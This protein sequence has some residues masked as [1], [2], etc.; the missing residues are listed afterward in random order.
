VT[1]THLLDAV[2]VSRRFGG[3]SALNG[4]TLH[5]DEA[6]IVGLIGPN[7]AGK[8]TFFDCIY[9]TIRPNSGRITFA[10]RD[11]S[12]QPEYRRSRLGLGR[13]FQ[14][15][16]LFPGMTA[17]DHLLVAGRSQQRDGGV[18][19][20]LA[21]RGRITQAERDE[22]LG[23]LEMLGIAD[24]AE[25]PIEAL[26]LGHGRLVE[27]GRALMTKPRLLLL[28][29]PSSGLDRAETTAMVDV[30]R[31][32][33]ERHHTAIVLV[34]HD[35]EMVAEVTER[36]YVLDIGRLIAEGPTNDVLDDPIV[37]QA[38]LGVPA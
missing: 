22:A 17:C 19:R 11:L 13:T 31:L 8:S 16:E 1:D 20:D 26:S 18:L 10:G 27:L 6:E 36:V 21:G 15:I 30:L 2:D 7:G 23:V 5:A 28:D 32:V 38:Y 24:E 34:E 33:R 25:R 35:V 14:R 12:L 37:R 4:V 3:V 9:G 29:E